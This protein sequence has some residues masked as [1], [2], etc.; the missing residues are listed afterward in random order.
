M[1]EGRISQAG[2]EM[3]EH[4]GAKSY[5]DVN[6]EGF[7]SIVLD[8]QPATIGEVY[9]ECKK[10]ITSLSEEGH[11]ENIRV[12]AEAD[13]DM[14]FGPTLLIMSEYMGDRLMA[15]YLTANV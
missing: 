9:E 12:A 13:G 14:F 11:L 10:L 2:I 6:F 1:S 7:A 8:A 5:L 15:E 4:I 3:L